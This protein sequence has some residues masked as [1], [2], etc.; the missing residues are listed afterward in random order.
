MTNPQRALRGAEI[1]NA[2]PRMSSLFSD[3]PIT[4]A[5]PGAMSVKTFGTPAGPADDVVSLPAGIDAIDARALTSGTRSLGENR[6][7]PAEWDLTA[8]ALHPD[9]PRS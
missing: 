5:I 6:R 8:S 1:A 2:S 3:R 9:Q 7:R 4:P